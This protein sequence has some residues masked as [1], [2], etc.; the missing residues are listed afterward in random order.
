MRWPP[1]SRQRCAL[2]GRP[3]WDLIELVNHE[4]NCTVTIIDADPDEWD[5]ML[6]AHKKATGIML[7]MHLPEPQQPWQQIESD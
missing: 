3:F 7:L 1:Q 4:E 2:C 6:A 5:R